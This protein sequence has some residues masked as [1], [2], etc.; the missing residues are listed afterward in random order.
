MQKVMAPSAAKAR[1]IAAPNPEE[2]PVTTAMRP[3]RRPEVELIIVEWRKRVFT[4]SVG[5][6]YCWTSP[7]MISQDR[8]GSHMS[9]SCKGDLQ[10]CWK[11]QRRQHSAGAKLRTLG[12][13]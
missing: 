1:Q 6:T 8:P 7:L 4:W 10:P 2:L 11:T 3:R 9:G 12:R 13:G 5:G